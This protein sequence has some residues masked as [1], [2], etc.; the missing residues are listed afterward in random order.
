[1]IYIDHLII[2]QLNS[3]WK[4]SSFIITSNIEFI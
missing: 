2:I 4:V 1:M 3:D